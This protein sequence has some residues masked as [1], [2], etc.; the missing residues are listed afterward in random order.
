[1]DIDRDVTA[2]EQLLQPMDMIE[3]GVRDENFRDAISVFL[4]G[5]EDRGDFPAR[6]DHRSFSR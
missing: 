4:C 6:I 1:M 3:M 2:L 5:L